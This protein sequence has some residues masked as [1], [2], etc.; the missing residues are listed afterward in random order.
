MREFDNFEPHTAVN[1]VY[2]SEHI[3]WMSE[4]CLREIHPRDE[5]QVNIL[6]EENSE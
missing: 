2:L 5:N 6:Y 3:S 4:A 1:F